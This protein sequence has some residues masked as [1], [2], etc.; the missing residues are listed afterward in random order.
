MRISGA[1][2]TARYT[3]FVGQ[4]ARIQQSAR[5]DAPSRRGALGAQRQAQ[6]V[7]VSTSGATKKRRKY[8]ERGGLLR[9][10]ADALC[11]CANEEVLERMSAW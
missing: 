2:Q 5:A 7:G 4:S 11:A 10:K 9:K 6:P 3:P 1:R 8:C